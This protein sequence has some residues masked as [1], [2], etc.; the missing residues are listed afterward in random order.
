MKKKL[1]GL[2]FIFTVIETL[3]GLNQNNFQP[4]LCFTKLYALLL[5][6]GGGGG[7][8][9]CAPSERFH[10]L[11]NCLESNMLAVHFRSCQS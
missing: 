11:Q 5:A 2:C 9:S 4:A 6:E 3:L 1:Y 10:A 8:E 7:E